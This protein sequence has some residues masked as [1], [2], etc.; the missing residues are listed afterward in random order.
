MTA[1]LR[2]KQWRRTLSTLQSSLSSRDIR[3]RFLEY[4]IH[5]N[6]HQYL[7]SSPVISHF[8]SSTPFVNAGMCQVNVF[9]CYYFRDSW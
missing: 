3:S 1:P 4:F 2:S 8:D 7:K 9:I 6:G 5:E